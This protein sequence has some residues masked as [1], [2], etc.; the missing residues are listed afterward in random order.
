MKPNFWSKSGSFKS[1]RQ[2]ERPL[3][4]DMVS[5]EVTRKKGREKSELTN[6]EVENMVRAD[7]FAPIL[8]ELL[9]M[10]WDGQALQLA[11]ALCELVHPGGVVGGG[12]RCVRLSVHCLISLIT[13][14][15]S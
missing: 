13:N 14:R 9:D 3:F 1:D 10:H 6:L 11:A 12:A 7:C 2:K 5:D 4:T 15:V 8:E